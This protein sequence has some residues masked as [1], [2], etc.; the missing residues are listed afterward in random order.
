MDYAPT[1]IGA[2]GGQIAVI[3]KAIGDRAGAARI[4][5]R[6]ILVE[7]VDRVI[8]LE[9]TRDIEGAAVVVAAFGE[10]L[11]HR[12]VSMRGGPELVN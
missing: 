12:R 1:G 6:D 8:A 5:G 10:D 7:P 11:A 4:V 9:A 2:V 3:V